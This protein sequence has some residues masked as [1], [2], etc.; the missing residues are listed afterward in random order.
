[1]NVLLIDIDGISSL[2]DGDR[3]TQLYVKH[4]RTPLTQ[5]SVDPDFSLYDIIAID[6]INALASPVTLSQ[7]GK[8]GKNVGELLLTGLAIYGQSVGEEARMKS[9]SRRIREAVSLGSTAILVV[10]KSNTMSSNYEILSHLTPG[11]TILR[12]SNLGDPNT[13]FLDSPDELSQGLFTTYREYL[14]WE[15]SFDFQKNGSNPDTFVPLMV[16]SGRNE[17]VAL[18]VNIEK[19]KLYIL[20]NV[21]DVSLRREYIKDIISYVIQRDNWSYYYLPELTKKKRI[22]LTEEIDLVRDF[23]KLLTEQGD[24][25]V[26]IVSKSLELLG[27]EVQNLDFVQ[28]QAN[29]PKLFDL[30]ITAP[31]FRA[32]IEVKGKKGTLNGTI[33]NQVIENEQRYRK[34]HGESRFD[35][36]ILILNHQPAKP[37]T[38]RDEFHEERIGEAEAKGITVV[39]TP[40]LLELLIKFKR[41][42]MD[43][44]QLASVLKQHGLI[45]L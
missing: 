8:Q 33:L 1:M 9:W 4:F 3:T 5:Q 37:P 30:I 23:I 13:V 35:S 31:N 41:R 45:T 16:N 20:P 7:E 29:Q 43:I 40:V 19:G 6:S 21:E 39:P 36:K 17:M 34:Q 38:D 2:K 22:E 32:S 12:R 18:Q 15:A 11:L 26:T 44:H 14:R 10:G 27:F 24:E 25:L 28:R 42:E